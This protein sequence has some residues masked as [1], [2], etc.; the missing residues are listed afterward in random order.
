MLSR[1][2]VSDS[3]PLHGPYPA[4]L[5]HPWNYLGKNTGTGHHFLLQG[6]FP[7][8]GPNLSF[9]HLLYFQANAFPLF[10]LGNPI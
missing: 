6:I 2:D 10:H 8:E 9:M 3:L 1:L 4:R 7:T 5:L